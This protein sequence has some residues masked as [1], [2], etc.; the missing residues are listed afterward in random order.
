MQPDKIDLFQGW[1]AP[2]I[3]PTERLKQAAITSL[4]NE[5]I[6][7][8]GC[9]Y[10]PDE[11]YLPLRESIATWL[12][13]CYTPTHSVTLERICISGGA[14]QNLA[15]VLQVFTDPAQ[16]QCIWLVE[17]TYHLVFRVFEDAGFSGRL[18]GISEDA[19]GMDVDALERALDGFDGTIAACDK[20]TKPHRPYRKIYKHIIYLVPTFSNPSGTTMSLPRR[21]SLIRVARK[22]DA[23]VICDDVYDFLHWSGPRLPRLVDIDR[24]LDSGPADR[25]GNVVSNGSFSKLIGPGCRVGWAEGMEDF[26]YGLSQA[27]STVSGGAPSQLMS[28]FVHDLFRDDFLPGYIT[29]TIIPTGSRRYELMKDVIERYL[30]PLGVIFYPDSYSPSAG[31]YYI[32]LRLPGALNATTVCE[33]ALKQQNL[34]L[35]NGNLFAVPGA[36]T[37]SDVHQR[38]RLCFM[39]VEEERLVE[40]Y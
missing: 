22:Y 31:G 17:P 40:V 21:E 15:C 18:R 35:G 28:T 33:E 39:W 14:S 6:S 4:S 16:T 20:P 7:S 10:G 23:L 9:A 32:W 12:T 24:T 3:I 25:F 27:G 5:S 29:N 19:D 11:G 8:Q 38:L 26:V 36:A 30:V 2:A 37:K 13:G 1:P 34:M